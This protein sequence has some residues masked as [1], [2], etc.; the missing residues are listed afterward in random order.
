ML[1]WAVLTLLLWAFIG[2]SFFGAAI[3]AAIITIIGGSL[4]DW[5]H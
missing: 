3:I 5:T 4:A 1:L 2:W